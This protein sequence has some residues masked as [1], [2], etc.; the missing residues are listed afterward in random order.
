MNLHNGMK[1]DHETEIDFRS[2][3][4]KKTFPRSEWESLVERVKQQREE[5][6]R[7]IRGQMWVPDP[8]EYDQKLRWQPGE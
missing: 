1:R 7:S 3:C 8:D 2:E 4:K 6:L 5:N